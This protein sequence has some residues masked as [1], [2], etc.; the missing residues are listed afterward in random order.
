M[1]LVLGFASAVT[2]LV[3]V[4]VDGLTLMDILSVVK[5]I[6]VVALGNRAV[7]EVRV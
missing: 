4:D 6:E 3:N 2:T 1:L 5:I 7:V